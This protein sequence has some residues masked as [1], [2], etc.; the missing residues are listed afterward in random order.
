MQTYFDSSTN[1]FYVVNRG[2]N[3]TQFFH[4]NDEGGSPDL[5]ALDKYAGKE[6][7][8]YIYFMPK[9]CVNFMQCELQRGLRI[10]QKQAEWITFKLPR[11]S[12]DFQTDLYPACEAGK[13]AHSYED[14]AAGANVDPVMQ[15]FDP[16]SVS[17]E[18]S[19]IDRQ[20]TFKKKMG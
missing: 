19:T 14:W 11:K 1:M 10:T 15:N 7:Q 4:F 20:S 18:Q 2:Q 16:N 17:V 9:K 12:G 8:L 6:N 3:F 5:T 13:E